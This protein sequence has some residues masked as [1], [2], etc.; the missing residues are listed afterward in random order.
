MGNGTEIA[1][2]CLEQ[3]DLKAKN[4]IEAADVIISKGQGNFETLS[5]CG[6][7]IYY[8]FLCKCEWFVKRFGMEQLKGVFI[9]D[10]NCF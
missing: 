7:N 6:L 9:N 3:I 10:R 1:G 5:G 2:T 8:L 4:C